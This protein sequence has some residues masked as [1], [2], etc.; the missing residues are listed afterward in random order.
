MKDPILEQSVTTLADWRKVNTATDSVFNH[1]VWKWVKNMMKP[2]VN[3]PRKILTPP[4]SVPYPQSVTT[5]ADW[6]K[7]NSMDNLTWSY[8][9]QRM[10][11]VKTN[12][13]HPIVAEITSFFK[14]ID[15]VQKKGLNAVLA[16]QRK[17]KQEE[18]NAKKN[19]NL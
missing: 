14:K 11:Y 19:Q 12:F 8:T 10:I 3:K 13:Y 16:F 15:S 5:L 9:E 4:W 7:A 17:L 1:P 18:T 6:R 2:R